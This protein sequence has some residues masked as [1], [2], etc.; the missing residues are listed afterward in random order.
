MVVL[1][2]NGK[3][4]KNNFRSC[5]LFSHLSR[6][7]FCSGNDFV[8]ETVVLCQHIS[9]QLLQLGFDVF[10][11]HI[12]QGQCFHLREKI[13]N[14][15]F[16]FLKQSEGKDGKKENRKNG[17]TASRIFPNCTKDT[18]SCSAPEAL[19]RQNH[20]IFALAITYN[21]VI[22]FLGVISPFNPSAKTM[23]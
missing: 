12:R 15:L 1:A 23:S 6:C 20:I 8:H 11:R 19:H 21:P 9:S 10:F 18:K 7:N 3:K 16:A 5:I 13:L 17:Y 4:N 2:I 14:D 22:L